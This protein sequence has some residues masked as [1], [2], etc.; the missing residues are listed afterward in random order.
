MA[1]RICASIP[2]L[3]SSHPLLTTTG[4]GRAATAGICQP[5]AHRLR[6]PRRAWVVGQKLEQ[7]SELSA[8]ADVREHEQRPASRARMDDERR[9]VQDAIE[10][11]RPLVNLTHVVDGDLLAFAA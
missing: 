3:Y 5:R 7:R 8:V 11:R 1:F 6:V 2:L 9:R 4:R 10:R